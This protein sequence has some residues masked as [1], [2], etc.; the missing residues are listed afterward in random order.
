[1]IRLRFD[2]CSAACQRSFRSECSNTSLAANC[3]YADLF[4]YLGLSATAA[5]TQR[6]REREREIVAQ[7][8]E[9]S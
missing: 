3:S 2:G 5:H 7:V 8:V 4:I 6:E 9:W 1:M